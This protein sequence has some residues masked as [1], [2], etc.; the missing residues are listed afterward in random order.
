[1][2]L[3]SAACVN[4]LAL[5]LERSEMALDAVAHGLENEFEERFAGAGVANPLHLTAR[6][7]RLERALPELRALCEELARS[8]QEL[9]DAARA[10]LRA[11]REALRALCARAGTAPAPPADDVYADFSEAM[12]LFEAQQLCASA[13]VFAGGAAAGMS[14]AYELA[15]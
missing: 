5:F 15:L 10:Q 13:G 11:N 4:D 12:A 6:V 9:V 1:M 8:K 2:A 3:L 7:R 14:R